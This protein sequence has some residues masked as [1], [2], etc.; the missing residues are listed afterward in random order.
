MLTMQ[1][2]ASTRPG[3]SPPSP[4]RIFERSRAMATRWPLHGWGGVSEI[5]RPGIRANLEQKAMT[6]RRKFHR[7]AV[8]TCRQIRT[9]LQLDASARLSQVYS[10]DRRLRDAL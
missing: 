1:A 4:T 2:R 5:L 6:L 3:T 8:Q 7:E 9:K 10:D